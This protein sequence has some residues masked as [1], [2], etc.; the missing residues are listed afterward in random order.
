[1]L[2]A[3]VL[4]PKDSWHPPPAKLSYGGLG[5]MQN[6]WEKLTGIRLRSREEK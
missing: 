1:M 4:L 2:G 5:T 6:M 3:E